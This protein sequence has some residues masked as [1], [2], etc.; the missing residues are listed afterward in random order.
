MYTILIQKLEK[1]KINKL[2]SKKDWNVYYNTNDYEH[3]LRQL[4]N[5]KEFINSYFNQVQKKVLQLYQKY[6]QSDQNKKK[7]LEDIF[8]FVNEEMEKDEAF[9]LVYNEVLKECLLQQ[10]TLFV[11]LKDDR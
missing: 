10:K 7:Q 5:D 4:K 1:N 2:F 6:D 11:Q 9:I 3:Q 8:E